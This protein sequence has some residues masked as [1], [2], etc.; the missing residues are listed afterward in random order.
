MALCL[1]LLA[2]LAAS[3]DPPTVEETAPPS[4]EQLLVQ[5][6]AENPSWVGADQCPK[7]TVFLDSSF[8]AGLS[9]SVSKRTLAAL[10]S[11]GCKPQMLS[12]GTWKDLDDKLLQA[13]WSGCPDNRF[14]LTM[15]LEEEG[16]SA[17]VAMIRWSNGCSGQQHDLRFVKREGEWVREKTRDRHSKFSLEVQREGTGLDQPAPVDPAGFSGATPRYRKR[18]RCSFFW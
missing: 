3:A 7:K 4:P 14:A 9:P 5:A 1:M 16:D 13:A 8:A 17:S 18:W 6:V 15:T 2:L 10:R 12:Y 11:H